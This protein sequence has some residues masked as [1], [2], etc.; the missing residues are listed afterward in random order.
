LAIVTVKT[1][2]DFAA[3]VAKLGEMTDAIVEKALEAG[4]EIAL[5]QVR[6]NL[7]GAIG[8]GEYSRPT[9]ELVSSLGISPVKVNNQGNYD[10]KIG[11]NEPRRKQTQAKG[12]RSYKVATNAMVAN[13]LEYGR[14]NQPARPF[15]APA[16]SASKIAAIAAMSAVVQEAVDSL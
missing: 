4:G 6:A 5:A 3:K 9:G 1:P 13:V 11:F 14:H 2:D 12:K 10:I 8:R 15:L 16:K 7:S